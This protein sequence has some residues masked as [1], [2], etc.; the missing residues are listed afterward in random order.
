[1]NI[2][3]PFIN[4]VGR[5]RS[6]WRFAIFI[7]VYAVALYSA[8]FLLGSFLALLLGLEKATK[9]LDTG[10]IFLIS[11]VIFVSVAVLACWAC[12]F[13]LE[14]LPFKAIGW[15]FHKGWLR[16]F[17]VG[18]ILG[19]LSLLF[20]VA[21]I[22][23]FGGYR[24]SFNSTASP[25]AIL[26]TVFLS[27]VIF[28]LSAAAEE[29]AFRGYPLQTMARSNLAWVAILLLSVF[30]AA[31][32]LRNPNATLYFTM[33]NTF[34][35]GI[36]L[37]LAY[38]KTRSL[39][40][41]LGAHW[42]WNWTMSAML[43]IPVSGITSITPAPLLRVEMNGPVW[44]NGGSYGV[45]GGIVCSLAVLISTVAIWLLPFV[46]PTEEMYK[47]TSQENPVNAESGFPSAEC[48]MRNA[49]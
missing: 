37:S 28:I 41:P 39:W 14:G 36:W 32:H 7:V 43:G 4:S 49:E 23:T 40:F 46:K 31:V 19:A 18:S 10:P 42:A 24:F 17:F 44:L 21:L 25:T 38:L 5:L 29:A 22:F 11:R 6:G 15:S 13:F 48:G 35:A 45:E 30:F 1:M 33:G 20:A 3:Y 26:R 2:S 47:L 16:D 34:L 8:F 9:F 27:L 12:G